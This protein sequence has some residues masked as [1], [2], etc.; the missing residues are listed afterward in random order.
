MYPKNSMIKLAY[1]DL[2]Q[3]L[4]QLNQEIKQLNEQIKQLQDKLADNPNSK[5]VSQN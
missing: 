1:I 2:N 4:H 3:Y 5:K